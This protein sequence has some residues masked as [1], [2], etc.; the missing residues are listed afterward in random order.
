MSRT[1]LVGIDVP[2]VKSAVVTR[3]PP[4]RLLAATVDDGIADAALLEED[5]GAEADVVLEYL[6]EVEVEEY[7]AV[8]TEVD[9]YWVTTGFAVALEGGE[10]PALLRVLEL[11]VDV[12]A[13]D[14]GEERDETGMDS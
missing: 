2:V 5:K 10:L 3:T 13:N 6:P 8:A 12:E 11:S 9:M 7:D 14:M 4:K 1:R